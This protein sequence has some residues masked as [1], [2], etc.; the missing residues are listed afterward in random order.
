MSA[1]GSP[2]RISIVATIAQNSARTNG[3]D[4]RHNPIGRVTSGRPPVLR[5][6]SVALEEVSPA[7]DW[8]PAEALELEW[9]MG[10][11]PG[12]DK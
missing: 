10:V 4:A 1:A 11:G 12:E 6:I 3:Y 5:K 7:L 9:G 8:Y 2:T